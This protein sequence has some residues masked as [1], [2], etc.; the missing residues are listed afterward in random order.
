MAM[1]MGLLRHEWVRFGGV[2]KEQASANPSFSPLLPTWDSAQ[3][4]LILEGVLPEGFLERTK[5]RGMVVKSW[6]P[7]VV[8]LKNES[9]GGFVTLCGW[10]LV[11]EAVVAG[12]SMIAWPLHA[13]QHMNMNVLATDME[14]AFAMEQRDEEDGFV[15][16]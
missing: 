4:T 16:V 5:D 15:T 10:N 9:V 12:V 11:L 6:A 14:M 2:G 8:V 7:Q 1:S 13:E 3:T